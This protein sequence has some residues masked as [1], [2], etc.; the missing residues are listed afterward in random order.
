MRRT[1]EITNTKRQWTR[2]TLVCIYIFYNFSIRFQNIFHHHQ[3]E[4]YADVMNKEKTV[5]GH[6]PIEISKLM[7]RFLR[8]DEGIANF[9]GKTKREIGLWW[10]Q[11]N[12]QTL[13]E[14]FASRI[15]KMGTA[16]DIR[17]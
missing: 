16:E 9:R 12:I 6:V 13:Y 2:K 5:V 11:E 1:K 3:Y 10:C 17:I 4:N 14:Y 7:F 15:N 8:C